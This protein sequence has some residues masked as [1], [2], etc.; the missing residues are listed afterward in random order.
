[1]A[2][3][4]ISQLS[5]ILS[6]Q[7]VDDDLITLVDSSETV[8][9]EIN[10][11]VTIE[12]F[13]TFLRDQSSV[14]PISFQPTF[15][16]TTAYGLEING[17]SNQSRE[18][19]NRV[20]NKTVNI[21]DISSV[22][23][24]KYGRIWD[25]TTEASS[26]NIL[27]ASG[28]AA[29]FYKGT[30]S[31]TTEPGPSSYD[32]VNTPV[33]RNVGG[34]F[35]SDTYYYPT[36][37]YATLVNYSDGTSDDYNWSHLFDQSYNTYDSTTVELY[38]SYSDSDTDYQPQPGSATIEVDWKNSTV[39]GT[40][41]FPFYSSTEGAINFPVIWTTTP[42]PAGSVVVEGLIQGAT[43]KICIPKILIDGANK[44]IRGLPIYTII[45]TAN[46]V[47]TNQSIAVNAVIT[48]T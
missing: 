39:K 5:T 12:Q 15:I 17:V 2:G 27:L 21:A 33:N 19:F 29:G 43:N 8:I 7:I 34:Y 26:N 47:I 16:E 10:K 37:K 46:N 11:K 9:T 3:K 35:N 44:K 20:S 28:T 42:I 45:D 4:K 41:S 13:N 18:I 48:S 32:N 14:F 25:L 36:E 6:D 38:Y 31:D 1:M 30:I 24:D 23:F 22:K 40:G